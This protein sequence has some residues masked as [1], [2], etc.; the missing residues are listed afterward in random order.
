MNESEKKDGTLPV[1]TAK[2]AKRSVTVIKGKGRKQLKSSYNFDNVFTAFSTQEDV[3]EATVKPVITDVMRGFESTVFAYGQTG[4][5]KTHTM[6]GSLSSP[7]LHGVIPRSAQAIFEHLKRPGYRE[8]RVTCSYLEI[9]NEELRDLLADDYGSG[10]GPPPSPGRPGQRPP[11]PGRPGQ[12]GGGR[13]DIMEGKNGT[14]CRGLTEK[15]VHSASDVLNLMRRA[16]HSRH[17]GETKMNKSSSR[18]HCLFTIQVHGK[19]ALLR[20]D[21]EMEFNGKLHMVDLAGSECAKSAGNDKGAPD[22]VARERERMNINRSLLTLG[23]VIT[24]LKEKVL[25][26]NTNARIPY[27]D[28][29]LTRVLQESLGG[30]CKT[31]IVATLSPSI[32]AIEESLSTLNYAHS[33]T[34][35]INK[36]VSSS[37]IALGESMPPSMSSDSKSS[38]NAPTIESWQEMD[39]R[40]QY[41]QAQVD[42]AQAAL[43]RKHLQQ[44]ELQDR[45]EKAEAELMKS[46]Q[47]LLDANNEITTLKGVVEEETNKRKHTEKEL[48]ETQI[49]LKKME[50]VLKA[51][52]ATESSLTTEA[53]TLI[54]KL[55]EI[56]G[57]RNDMHALVVSHRDA[58]SQRKEAAKQFQEASL[59]VLNSIESS[60]TDL[61]AGIDTSQSS[62]IKIASMNHEVGRHSVTET[63]KLISDIAQNVSCVTASIK[64][65]LLGEG[66]IVPALETGSYTVLSAV[67]SA[68]EEFAH[69]EKSLEES[70]EDMRKRLEQCTR[71]LE[72]H[73]SNI[74]MSTGQA[75]QSFE[76]KV[77]E[78]KNAISHLVMTMKK[79][80]SNLSETKLE[81]AKMLDSLMEQWRDQSLANSK[82]VLDMTK[83][84]SI[85]LKQS[86]DVFQKE[87]HN[88]KQMKKSLEDQ[89]SF[90]D[91]T[92]SAH[93]QTIDQQGSLLNAHRQKLAES[94]DTQSRLCDEVM[95]S[96]MSGVQ[97][98]VSSEI[99]K[100]AKSQMNHFQV[101]D[102]D[103]IDLASVNER[104]TQS[105]KLV[106]EEMNST[107]RLM[108]DKAFIVCSNDLKACEAMRSSQNTLDGVVASSNAHQE[109]TDDFALK[110]LAAVSEMK[111]LDRQNA[112]VAKIAEQDGNATSASLVNDVLKPT[113]SEMEKAL[114]TSLD[115]MAYVNGDVVPN[116]NQALED[117]ARNRKL[118]ADQISGKIENA[119]SQLSDMTGHVASMAKTQHSVAER[120]RNKTLTASSAHKNESVPYYYAELDSGKEKLLSTMNS[121]AE[122]SARAVSEGKAQGSIVKQSVEDFA[123]NKMECAK[124]V[125]PAP[126]RKECNFSR[127]LPATPAEDEILKGKVFDTSWS[128]SGDF[129]ASS[130]SMAAR[131]SESPIHPDVDTSQ[132]SQEEEDVTNRKSSGSSSSLPS[133]RLKFRDVNAN[134]G[135]SSV[136]KSRKKHRTAS[137]SSLSSRKNKC[138][139]G[140]QSSSKQS[141][142]RMK[143]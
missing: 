19:L 132:E 108:S 75:L 3:F 111:Q 58:E 87:M 101:L 96:I 46:Q 55:E 43:A 122:S 118:V 28:S 59:V 1:V 31:I 115:A 37:L 14:F 36:P 127:N 119:R 138:P 69:G 80:L 106:M 89:R 72:E 71:T 11:S 5:G 68:N 116:V 135:D 103:G 93:V 95:Q 74:Q 44:Q 49:H 7:E 30:R 54:G 66:G 102:K 33:A 40:L 50:M 25:G 20:G 128:P 21:G 110:S 90:L 56:I 141:R 76:S 62:A 13:L 133:P 130:M 52:Q 100:L 24:V 48:R 6:E 109:L 121:L 79:S 22:A 92:G 51:T 45:A 83:P 112:E 81:K 78:S 84:S 70:R 107:N 18:S 61:I 60:F 17:I 35:I 47:Q 123:Q 53:R 26:K 57:D 129:T 2:T 126:S 117:V 8:Q 27:R 140:Q 32:T 120:L 139:S 12:R 38:P 34:G 142:K 63:Q 91:N 73:A 137:I 82:T 77:V 99:E 65:Q 124:P 97:S 88:H 125:D 23:R 64:A 104:I 105:A 94:H 15:Q 9:Y 4:T 113:S 143:R 131:G 134:Q 114:Q 67:Q 16:Q 41:M 42:E 86:I 136:L 85:S 39:M 29:K 10:G 98:L